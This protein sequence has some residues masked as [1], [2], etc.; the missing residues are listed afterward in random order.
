MNE[1]I[2]HNALWSDPSP[3]L[4]TIYANRCVEEM[5]GFSFQLKKK[6]EM[7]RRESFVRFLFEKI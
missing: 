2:L 5:E 6:K 7:A 3:L 1:I 4:S